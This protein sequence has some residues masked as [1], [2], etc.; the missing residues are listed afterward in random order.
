MI[1]ETE[2]SYQNALKL[3]VSRCC[4]VSSDK[5][6]I[7]STLILTLFN[8]PIDVGVSAKTPYQPTNTEWENC[9]K[10]KTE[11]CLRILITIILMGFVILIG[12]GLLYVTEENKEVMHAKYPHADC[13]IVKSE[14]G[15]AENL[16]K[17]AEMEWK[18]IYKHGMHRHTIE[19]LSTSNLQCFCDDLQHEEGWSK[20]A[21]KIFDIHLGKRDFRGKLCQDYMVSKMVIAFGYILIPIIIEVINIFVKIFINISGKILKFQNKTNEECVIFLLEFLLTFFD[22]TVLILLINA[23]FEG[24][25]IPL[26]FFQGHYTDFNES[27]Y[28]HVAPLF[29]F[30]MFL[31]MFI[32]IIKFVFTYLVKK[33]LIL[34]DKRGSCWKMCKGSQVDE[35]KVK[36]KNSTNVFTSKIHNNEYV[37]LHSGTHFKISSPFAKV[38]CMV[39][40]CLMFGVGEPIMFPCTLIFIFTIYCFNRLLVVYW[41]KKPPQFDDSLAKMFISGIKYGTILYCGFAYW[42]LTNRQMFENHVIPIETQEGVKGSE[43]SIWSLSFNQS[44][45]LYVG[46]FILI[47][48]MIF[49]EA[50]NDIF[51]FYSKKSIKNDNDERENLHNFYQSLSNKNL[52]YMI[53]EE[54]VVREKYGKK[55]LFDDT[56]DNLNKEHELRMEGKQ[57]IEDKIL[58]DLAS[59]QFINQPEYCEEVGYTPVYKRNVHNLSIEKEDIVDNSRR[60][61]DYPYF[62]DHASLSKDLFFSEEVYQRNFES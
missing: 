27:W 25:G 45:F 15:S 47:I 57:F 2:D 24:S 31:K 19:E 48:Y 62:G 26:T 22:S 9:H 4:C 39:F 23:N 60:V 33:L 56:F 12:F 13:S 40:M 58:F 42:I 32:P 14:A 37:D 3:G 11:R 54:R 20:A 17:F 44:L 1:F 28:F 30:L 8:I 35:I 18:N 51:G 61:F 59:Y 36:N 49:Y 34:F 43:H 21:N 41:F 10:S 50:I 5:Q 29:L 46:F 38:M 55:K 52:S 7:K 6:K 53:E 16:L